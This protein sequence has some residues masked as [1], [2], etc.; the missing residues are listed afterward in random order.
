MS[1]YELNIDG[2]VGPTHNYAGLSVGNI[3]SVVNALTVANPKA[4]ALQGLAKMRLLHEHGVKQALLPPHQ[5]P[6]LHLLE[7]LGFTG[8]FVQ[9]IDK[10]KK[11]APGL[12]NAVYSASSMWA[13]NAATVTASI[14]TADRKV[15]FTAANLISNL[16]RQQEAEFS[17][18]LLK[19]I[20]NDER[21]FQHHPILPPS[22]TTS[23]EGA[24]N[25]NRLCE[26]HHSPA[27]Y[28]LVYDKQALAHRQINPLPKRY[29]ARQ[30]LE[31]SKAIARSHLL[32]P[33]QVV[34]AC[35]NPV[36]IDQG[37]FHNDVISVANESVFLIH[38][39]AFLNQAEVLKELK[40][41]AP[42]VLNIIEI[43]SKEMS[44]DDA[45]ST[46]FFN[47]QL[48]TIPGTSHM[49]FI[50]PTECAEHPKI[51]TIIQQMIADDRNPINKVY[52]MELKQSM[53]NGGGPACLRLRVPLNDNELKAMHQG[54][55][56][57][58]HLL[59]M[60]ENWIL[61]HYRNELSSDDF[62]DPQLIEENFKALDELTGI[63]RLGPIYP[64]QL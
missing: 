7:Q 30:T 58:E 22:S 8:S 32:N 57:D 12:L 40:K 54:V 52:Y 20:F 25:H 34:F 19:I 43:P 2:L 53:R 9:K 36:A 39:E 44:I 14:D 5:R 6:N 18:K 24:A 26:H 1:V 63:L 62:N 37:V 41:K 33:E 16:H 27:V 13:A 61:R 29:P 48:I 60:L 47:S 35:Q 15:H 64:F 23:D 56:I 45:V 59:N 49:M 50:A 55:I 28:L 11:E 31:A 46:Y 3:A 10:A 21:F 42:F 51:N 38:E 17:S 4:A